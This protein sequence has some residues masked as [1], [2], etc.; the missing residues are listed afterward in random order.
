MANFAATVTVDKLR[1]WKRT[2]QTIAKETTT[3]SATERFRSVD[4]Q[5]SRVED[6]VH[7]AVHEF[8]DW[9]NSQ[10]HP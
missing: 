6:L 4:E 7:Q 1:Q 9:V 3:G 5:F 8:D 10:I 2:A